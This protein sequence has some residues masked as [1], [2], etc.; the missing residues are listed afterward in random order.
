MLTFVLDIFFHEALKCVSFLYIP[1]YCGFLKSELGRSKD[2]T[3][4]VESVALHQSVV[5]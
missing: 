2:N 5:K 4:T 1:I 3:I